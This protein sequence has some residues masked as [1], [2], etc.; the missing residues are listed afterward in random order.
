MLIS[1]NKNLSKLIGFRQKSQLIPLPEFPVPFR[2]SHKETEIKECDVQG[3]PVSR[4][5]EKNSTFHWLF[6]SESPVKT[7]KRKIQDDEQKI[8]CFLTEVPQADLSG[9]YLHL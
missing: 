8:K 2:A 5:L 7:P 3:D 4:T 1:Y 6:I 9:V